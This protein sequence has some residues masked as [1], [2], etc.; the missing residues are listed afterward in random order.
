MV[1]QSRC[2]SVGRWT[3]ALVKTVG[4]TQPSRDVG[5]DVLP[6]YQAKQIEQI[7]H[8]CM[9]DVLD[10]YFVFLRTRVMCGEI[11]LKTE[12]ARVVAAKDWIE[13]QAKT[14]AGLDSYLEAWGAWQPWI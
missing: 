13:T 12:Q 11:D 2:V 9:H 7:N 10:T 1:D 6:M 3:Q 5:K 14:I 8:Y 4:Q